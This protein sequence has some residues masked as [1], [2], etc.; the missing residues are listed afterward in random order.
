[1]AFSLIP[2]FGFWA[3]H[4]CWKYWIQTYQ[5][6]P[7]HHP[8]G[9]SNSSINPL[10]PQSLPLYCSCCQKQCFTISGFSNAQANQFHVSISA[11]CCSGA[12]A[13]LL[14]LFYHGDLD[15]L[16]LILYEHNLLTLVHSLVLSSTTIFEYVKS[17]IEVIKMEGCVC[18]RR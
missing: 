2:P 16:H 17:T 11:G 12:F 8:I 10:L 6:P 18:M 9:I 7:C 4:L 15:L 5:E 1:M 3:S 14:I 13:S